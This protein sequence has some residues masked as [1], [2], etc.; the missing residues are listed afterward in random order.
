MTYQGIP[1]LDFHAHFPTRDATWEKR[2]EALVAEIGERRAGLLRQGAH[3]YNREWRLTWDFPEP[4]REPT[5]MEE[6]ADRWLAELD[7]YGIAKIVWVTGGGNDT[8]G[9]IVARHPTRFI[10]FAHHDPFSEG[11]ADELRR[12]VRNYGFRGYKVLAPA[13]DRPIADRAAWPVWEACAELEL[14][15]LIHFG[16]MGSGGGIMW[17]P[18][19]NPL[20]LHDVAKSFPDVTFVVPHFGCGYVRETLHLCWGCANVYVD[21]SGSNQWI[22]WM[23][24]DLTVK[25]LLRKYLETIGPKRLIFGTDSSWFPRG[26]AIRYLQDQLRDGRELGLDEESLCLIFGGNAARLLRIAWPPESDPG[27]KSNAYPSD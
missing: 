2:H 20:T 10:G 23:P 27:E 17:H 18:N 13:L 11:A 3:E 12:S 25:K 8:L 7:R 14:P 16:P 6:L 24:E 21:T 15:V 26:F 22:R 5:S 19:I 1:I 9:S 4:D